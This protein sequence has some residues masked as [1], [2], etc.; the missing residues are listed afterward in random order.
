MNPNQEQRFSAEALEDYATKVFQNAGLGAEEAAWSAESLVQADMRG[1]GSHGLMRLRTYA[2]R[3]RCGVVR[4]G[5]TPR[6]VRESPSFLLVDGGNGIGTSV[7]RQV[8]QLCIDRARQSGACFA[9]V[10]NGNHFGIAA[11]FT[12]LAAEA[13]M[14]GI[15]M[16]NAPA[17]MVPTGGRKP[18][19][20]ANPMS[21][22]IPAGKHPPLVLD[23]ATSTVA[24]GKI[25]LAAKE[26]KTSIPSDWAVDPE[27]NPTTDP[28]KALQGAMLPF[29]GAKG[30]GLALIIDI[31][32]A[33][34]SG[35]M[36]STHI[37]NFWKDFE[38]PQKLGF[39]IGAWN[40]GSVIPLPEFYQRMDALIQEIKACP[41][42]PGHTE[43]F[44]PGEIEHRRAQESI[45]QGIALGPAVVDDLKKL[46]E[47]YSAAFPEP[48]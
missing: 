26:G 32:V 40:I 47:E 48:V 9:T 37:N 11:S 20:G 45:R 12:E 42:A 8:M 46:A 41:P 36:T 17:S 7:A 30:Y 5:V 44:C 4:S 38:N 22:A 2:Q 14:I 6:I 34:L 18:L 43:V 21:I 27:G 19:L 10:F 31:L 13:G 16:S 29:G 23:M 28:K 15:A 35:A 33:V 25:I 3:A 24:Q 1:V 39:F